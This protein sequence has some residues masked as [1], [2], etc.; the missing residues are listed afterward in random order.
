MAPRKGGGGVTGDPLRTT[1]DYR[2]YNLTAG[3]RDGRAVPVGSPMSPGTRRR[4]RLFDPIATA[5]TERRRSP[6]DANHRSE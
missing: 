3:L 5:S 4:D 1:L 6:Q 2:N